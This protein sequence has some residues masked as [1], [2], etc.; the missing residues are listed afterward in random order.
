MLRLNVGVLVDG[1]EG[2]AQALEIVVGVKPARYNVPRAQTMFH[3]DAVC[4]SVAIANE[5]V[6]CDSMPALAR[7]GTQVG[8]EGAAP[9]DL[10]VARLTHAR[11]VVL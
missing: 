1:E 10:I 6:Q 8:G 11:C 5:F 3:Q 4:F 7:R 2:F 9:S